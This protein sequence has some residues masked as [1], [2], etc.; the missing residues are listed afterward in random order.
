MAPFGFSSSV[1]GSASLALAW[2]PRSKESPRSGM[3]VQVH[4]QEDERGCHGG[5]VAQD[6]L[7]EAQ[8]SEG[9]IHSLI[10]SLYDT[11]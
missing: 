10:Y 4:A 11:W 3:L 8:R 1:E 5:E 6:R 7:P 2:Y 9:D